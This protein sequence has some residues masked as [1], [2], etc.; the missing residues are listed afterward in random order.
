MPGLR[1]LS[2]VI[3]PLRRKCGSLCSLKT[4][5]LSSM[6]H[7]ATWMR[8]TGHALK[9]ET[10]GNQVHYPRRAN[11]TGSC[12]MTVIRQQDFISS[13]AGALQYISFYHP[14]DYITSL[15]AAYEREQSPAARDAMAQILIN[16]RMC[17]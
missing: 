14:V 17:A 13:V 12:T 9:R 10:H 7:S 16:S 5:P 4:G 8:T 11:F 15:A 6:V 1:S 2:C 3:R